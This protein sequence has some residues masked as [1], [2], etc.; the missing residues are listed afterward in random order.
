[1][2]ALFRLASVKG[3]ILIDE[4]DVG[5]IPLD[6]LRSKISI[7]PQEPVLFSATMRYN[8]DP[9]GEFEDADI[10]NVLGQVNT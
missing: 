3:E 9:F 5:N 2:S 8:L 4:V 10:W 7:I 6:K 1:M